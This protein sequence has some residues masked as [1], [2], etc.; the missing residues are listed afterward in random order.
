MANAWSNTEPYKFQDH[1][2]S[3]LKCFALI[4]RLYRVSIRHPSGDHALRLLFLSI[5]VSGCKPHCCAASLYLCQCDQHH[6]HH[7][8][9]Y[10]HVLVGYKSQTGS[11]AVLL[12]LWQCVRHTAANKMQLFV[13]GIT[14]ESESWSKPA[15]PS[16][17]SFWLSIWYSEGLPSFSFGEVLCGQ[18]TTWTTPPW[19]FAKHAPY[20]I[21]VLQP[22]HD[23]RASPLTLKRTV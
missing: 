11:R 23:P 17:P 4:L 18:H 5:T 3:V 1:C 13:N 19:E 8:C 9:H 2:W 7:L 10:L 12:Q 6:S 22:C 16:T 15:T 20:G 14:V 21:Q